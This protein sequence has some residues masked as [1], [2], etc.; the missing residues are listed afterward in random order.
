MDLDEV[1]ENHAI[2]YQAPNY[3]M[4]E[5]RMGQ[6]KAVLC[7]IMNANTPRTY[8][9]VGCGRGEMLHY[10]ADF[11]EVKGVELVP[12]LCD[13]DWII[14]G[15]LPHLPFGDGSYDVVSCFDVME[16]IPASLAEA[17]IKELGRIADRYLVMTISNIMS[18]HQGRMLHINRRPYD[19]WDA[20]LAEWLPRFQV[21]RSKIQPQRVSECWICARR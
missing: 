5:G 17:S 9:D 4:G 10:M 16:H 18:V 11:A 12:E 13:G 20:L 21:E 2:A 6:A 3:R 1:R 15:A 7:S 8:L 14:E 19:E